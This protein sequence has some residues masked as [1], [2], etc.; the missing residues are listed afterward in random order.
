MEGTRHFTSEASKLK[1]P[2]TV[3]ASVTMSPTSFGVT[4]HDPAGPRRFDHME[5]SAP[6]P[7]PHLHGQFNT[8][9]VIRCFMN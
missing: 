6:K 2:V 7:S 5:N 9:S 1:V 3:V 4:L 8:I